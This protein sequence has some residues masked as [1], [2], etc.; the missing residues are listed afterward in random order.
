[1]HVQAE[2]SALAA[3]FSG[4]WEQC[5]DHDNQGHVFLDFDPDLFKH[6]LFYLRSRTMLSSP[7]DKV[8]FPQ[9]ALDKQHAFENLIKYLALEEYMGCGACTALQFVAAHPSVNLQGQMASAQGDSEGFRSINAG[10]LAGDVCYMKCKAHVLK[11]W[12]FVGVAAGIDVA[13]PG[14]SHLHYADPSSFGWS[15]PRQQFCCGKQ[16]SSKIQLQIGDCI[17]L[18]ADFVHHKLSLRRTD[19]SSASQHAEMTFT[20]AQEQHTRAFFHVILYS[21]DDKVELLQ[22]TP[23]DHALLP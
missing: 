15:T 9:V 23:E 18:K 19:S 5:L 13:L 16:S 12:M 3:R 10:S 6:I 22:V 11:R 21:P 14:F 7:D 8:P 2:G 1:M 17:L 4:H 20:L